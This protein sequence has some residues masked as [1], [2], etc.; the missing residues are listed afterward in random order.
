MRRILLTGLLTAWFALP[1]QACPTCSIGVR[2]QVRA[3]V[4]GEDFGRNL[5][6]TA[7]P[8]AFFLGIAAVIHGRPARHW[9]TR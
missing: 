7:L 8:F 6:V 2:E 9:G 5:V 1:V 3:E 4:F